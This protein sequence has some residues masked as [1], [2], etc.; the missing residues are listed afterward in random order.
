MQDDLK[1]LLAYDTV[2][3]MGVLNWGSL[4]RLLS[5][6]GRNH[7]TYH[8]VN[9]WA[10]QDAAVLVCGCLIVHATG[11][12]PVVGDGWSGAARPQGSRSRSSGGLALIAGAPPPLKRLRLPRTQTRS[13]VEVVVLTIAQVV[14][15]AAPAR[16]T[17]PGVSSRGRDD[18]NDRIERPGAGM[19][20]AFGLL[21]G[22]WVVFRDWPTLVLD[23]VVRPAAGSLVHGAE[24]A[25]ATLAGGGRVTRPW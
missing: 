5:E 24:Y 19:L 13:L 11:D 18:A 1:R 20:V 9:H 2:S 16:A 23:H 17:H 3:Q 4:G 21:A 12:D 10:V 25:R 15:V 14:T 7:M 6:L 22:A 8:L